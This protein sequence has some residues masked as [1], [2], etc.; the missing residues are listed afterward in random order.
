M[1][2]WKVREAVLAGIVVVS[3]IALLASGHSFWVAAFGGVAAAF[4]GD[5]VVM[6]VIGGMTLFESLRWLSR[7]AARRFGRSKP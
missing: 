3:M 6:L 2:R 4:L 5:I 1:N 7:W